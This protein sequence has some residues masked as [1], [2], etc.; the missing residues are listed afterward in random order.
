MGLF[1]SSS[2]SEE[3]AL[4]LFKF[5]LISAE[6]AIPFCP[7]I[8]RKLDAHGSSGNALLSLEAGASMEHH[9]NVIACPSMYTVQMADR[10]P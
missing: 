10:F 2:S 1:Q 7:R 4:A 9:S 8:H 3:V 5:L 6:K